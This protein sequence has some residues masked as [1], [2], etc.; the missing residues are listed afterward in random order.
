MRGQRRYAD[1]DAGGGGDGSFW[2][3][4]NQAADHNDPAADDSEY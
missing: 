1:G 3:Q 2:A 4:S